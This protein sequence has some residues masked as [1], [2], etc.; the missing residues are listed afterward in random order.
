MATLSAAGML[1]VYFCASHKNYRS[2]AVVSVYKAVGASY[3]A[4]LSK[5]A[6]I[7]P[8]ASYQACLSKFAAIYSCAGW[9]Y[10]VRFAASLQYQTLTTF[11]DASRQKPDLLLAL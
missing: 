4:C 6:A 1:R 11:F 5:F 2:K 7:L 9:A 3:Q 10:F 8:G